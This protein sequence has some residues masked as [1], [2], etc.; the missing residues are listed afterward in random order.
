[1]DNYVSVNRDE[2]KAVLDT[3]GI[4]PRAYT[5]DGGHPPETCVLSIR[6]GGWAVYYSERGLESGRKDFDTEDAACEHLLSLLRR[7][8]TVHFEMVVGPLPADEADSQFRAWSE[9]QGLTLTEHDIR[10][11]NPILQQGKV[12]RYWVRGTI[13]RGLLRLEP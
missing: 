7:D 9:R 6:A 2:L 11:D 12:R 4:T 5:L 3:E 1:M 13:L 10:V 8:D